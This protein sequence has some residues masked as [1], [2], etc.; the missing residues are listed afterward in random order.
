LAKGSHQRRRSESGAGGRAA[1]TGGFAFREAGEAATAAEPRR[2]GAWR[3]PRIAPI[4][5]TASPRFARRNPGNGPAR[6]MI[7]EGSASGITSA[8]ASAAIRPPR[9]MPSG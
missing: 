1:G 6:A 2:E 7:A 4:T 5:S 8:A 3:S 9:V